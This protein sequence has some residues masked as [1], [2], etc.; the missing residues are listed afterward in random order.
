MCEI[1]DNKEILQILEKGSNRFLPGHRTCAGCFIPTIMRTVLGTIKQEC[2]VGVATGCSEVTTTLWPHTSW[3]VSYIHNTFETAAV[4]ISGAESA[5][6]VMKRKGQIKKDIKFIAF[7]GDGGTFDIGLQALSGVL[8]R[9]HNMMY[10]LYDNGAYMNCLPKDSLI[11]TETGLKRIV[12]VRKNELVYGIDLKSKML[13][14]RKCIG[15]YDNGIKE[16]FN[17]RTAHHDLNATKNHPFLVIK[18][19]KTKEPVLVWKTINELKAG[20][21]VVTLKN[22]G[23]NQKYKFP[24]I[25]MVKKG[26]YKVTGLNEVN[27]PQES[28]PNIM[29]FLGLYLGDGW[30]RNS[31]SEIGFSI[32]KDSVERKELVKVINKEL[33]VKF[34]EDKNEVHISSVNLSRFIDKLGFGHGAKNK[35]IPDWVFFLPI[36]EREAFIKGLLMSDGYEVKGSKSKRYVSA[37]FDLIKRLR[38]LLQISGFQVGKIHTLKKNKGDFVVYRELKTDSLCYYIAFSEL[39]VSDFKKWP[40][41]SKFRNYFVDNKWFNVETVLEIKRIGK[42]NTYDLQVEDVHNFI[43]DGFVVHNTGIQRSSATPYGASTTTSPSGRASIGKPENRKDIMKIVSAHNIP[44]AAQANPYY[45]D[46]FVM[47]IQRAAKTKGPSFL[48]VLMPCTLG[49]KFPTSDTAEIA[50]LATESNY[51]PLYEVENGRKYTLNYEPKEKLNVENFLKTQG[52]FG[53]LFKP[54]PRAEELKKIQKFVD[55]EFEYI[56]KMQNF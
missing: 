17:V 45:F 28:N 55:S 16:V 9:G 50:K 38:L 1:M 56:K 46:D 8:E 27:L 20:D 30:V 39:R 6:N 48:S 22:L 54:K 25:K 47:K 53:H 24:K 21:Q 26:D 5:Y 29:R 23:V 33:N 35:T 49:W 7:A 36:K 52:R 37:S 40:S 13:T 14:L 51:W 12:D 15:V 43:A 32:P 10:V 34:T 3:N 18:H 42:T 4:T 44:Y 2:V 19:L 31:R 11:F 41:Q